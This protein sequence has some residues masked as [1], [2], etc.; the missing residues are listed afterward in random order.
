MFFFFFLASAALLI[1]SGCSA[2]TPSEGTDVVQ[3]STQTTEEAVTVSASAATEEVQRLEAGV[4]V[5]ADETSPSGYT[6]SFVYYADEQ[7]NLESVSVTGPFQYVSPDLD[8]TSEENYFTPDEYQ[9]GM[10]PTGLVPGVSSSGYTE[11][12]IYDEETGAYTASFPITSGP[13]WY[14][15]VL[16]YQDGTTENIADPVNPALTLENAN[17]NVGTNNDVKSPVYG[18][19]DEEKQTGSPD[20]DFVLPSDNYGSLTYVEYTGNLS[21]DQ[22]L[23][24]YL[25]SGYDADREEPYNVIYASHGGGGNET[26]W[27]AMGHAD[28]IVAN[29][30]RDV[31]VVTMDN[32]SYDWDF[33]KIE[34]N[35]LNYIIPYME[36]NYNVSTEPEGRAFCGL[37]MGSMTTFHMYFDHPEEFAYFGAFSG[38]DMSAVKDTEGLEN[39]VFYITVG[40]CD[41]AS[42]NIQ[43]NTDGEEKK[44]EDFIAYLEENPMDNVVDGG[45]LPGGHDWFTWSQAFVAFVEETGF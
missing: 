38:S 41:I 24:I 26:V 23:G 1:M 37:S 7:E 11:E 6:V 12:M 14:S 25:P 17:S 10:Y 40:T 13:F 22:D 34:D 5:E 16:T 45:Y 2:T 28:N 32:T 39:S 27:F 19:Y 18:R 35:V 29:L 31:I 9:A 43:Q 21:D 15:Y 3:E 42:S 33:E 44:Y 8:V 20:L 36:K 30:G 4:S